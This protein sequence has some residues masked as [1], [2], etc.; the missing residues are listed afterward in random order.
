M[1]EFIFVSVMCIGQN[2]DFMVSNQPISYEKCQSIKKEFLSLPFKPEVTLAAA[3]C[4]R[5][6]TGEKV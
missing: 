6:D 1:I 2:C 4:M 3:Q 5:I